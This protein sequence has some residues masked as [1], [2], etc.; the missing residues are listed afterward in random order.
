MATQPGTALPHARAEAAVQGFEREVRLR[1]E[2][3]EAIKRRERALAEPH[4]QGA[5]ADRDLTR[6]R[7][8]DPC[9]PRCAGQPPRRD[10]AAARP[11]CSMPSPRLSASGARPR[12]ILPAETELKRREKALREVQEKLARRAR[13]AGESRGAARIR[14]VSG[15]A[16]TS[17]AIREP[18]DCSPEACLALAAVKPA[19]A[20]PA[21]CRGRRPACPSSRP[22]ANGLAASTFVPRRRPSPERSSRSW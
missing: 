22:I 21:A 5:P 3:L 19:Q 6:A 18:L 11:A 10:R 9:R 4:R 1:Q 13:G 7:G 15:G 17:H 2:R 12:T 20:P 8:R 16:R 14:R